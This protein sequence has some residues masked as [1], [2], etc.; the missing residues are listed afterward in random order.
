MALFDPR[1]GL[2]QAEYVVEATHD[3]QHLLWVAYYDRPDPRMPKIEWESISTGTGA[4][5]G[6]IDGRP[7]CLSIFFARING[8][9]VLF[10]E[11]TS[12]VV[13]YVQV[14]AWLEKN[15]PA[16]TAETDGGRRPKCNT[17]NFGHCLSFC[18]DRQKERAA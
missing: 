14:E 1:E 10:W 7:I 6:E 9:L 13:D 5:V 18:R 8:V 4:T 17:A 16:Y 11:P 15:V 2:K 3:E 12:Q